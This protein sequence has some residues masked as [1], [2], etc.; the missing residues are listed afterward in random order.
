ME[1]FQYTLVHYIQVDPSTVIYWTSPFV[2]L[3]MSGLFCRFYSILWKILLT[4]SAD[5]NQTPHYVASDLGLHCLPLTL[6]TDFQVRMGNL[7]DF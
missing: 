7:I 5:L 1:V 2:I 4:N 6:F 3:G